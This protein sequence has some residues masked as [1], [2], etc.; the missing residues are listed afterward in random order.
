MSNLSSQPA[1]PVCSS[2]EEHPGMTY[3]QW[4][5]GMAMQ[6]LLSKQGSAGRQTADEIEQSPDKCAEWSVQYADALIKELEK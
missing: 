3:R 4:L 1:F 5:A 6:G 2:T